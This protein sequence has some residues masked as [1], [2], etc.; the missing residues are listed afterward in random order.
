MK[1]RAAQA[2]LKTAIGTISSQVSPA[3]AHLRALSFL[4]ARLEHADSL[5]YARA[6]PT[7]TGDTANSAVAEVVNPKA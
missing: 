6:K 3:S 4:K 7:G 5:K 2:V 1:S